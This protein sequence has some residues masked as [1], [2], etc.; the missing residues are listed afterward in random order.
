MPDVMIDLETASTR[1]DAVI[2]S[3]G[4]VAFDR[5]SES[6]LDSFYCT[7][8]AE[9]QPDRN[10]S[11]ST[12]SWWLSQSKEA[13]EA[14]MSERIQLPK[15]LKDLRAF[16]LKHNPESIWAK[17]P[18]FDLRILSHAYGDNPPWRYWQTRSVRTIQDVFDV[19]NPEY[20]AH[21]ALVDAQMQAAAVQE[22]YR[23]L[24]SR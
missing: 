11:H 20:T 14:L 3:I 7:I 1:F 24:N 18:D 2:L 10:I 23:R 6:F 21:N 16:I 17:D 13:Q 9:S 22:G 15:A 8:S 19:P 5:S 4:A 12:F